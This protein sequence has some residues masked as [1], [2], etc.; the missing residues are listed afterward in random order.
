MAFSHRLKFQS[1]LP[2]VVEGALTQMG[3]P[4]A[5]DPA[6]TRHIAAF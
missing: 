5:Q 1:S 6:I 2:N 4:Y 3:L